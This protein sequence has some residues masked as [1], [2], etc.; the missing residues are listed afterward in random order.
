MATLKANAWSL[1]LPQS[2][3]PIS[4]VH[5][6]LNQWLSQ[7]IQKCDTALSTLCLSSIIADQ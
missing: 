1:C 6:R 4:S 3:M 7:T 5:N 2:T